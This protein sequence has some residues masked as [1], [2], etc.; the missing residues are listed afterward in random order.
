M[1]IDPELEELFQE[2]L[3]SLKNPQIKIYK[4]IHVDSERVETGS[5][6]S[7]TLDP[8]FKLEDW[9]RLLNHLHV[10]DYFI[11]MED[12]ERMDALT[13]EIANAWRDNLSALNLRYRVCRF[14]DENGPGLTFYFDRQAN[15]TESSKSN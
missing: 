2:R 8:K 1:V 11:G 3:R 12:D 15:T 6:D 9:E 13:N 14:D 4:G 5:I 10:R 7:F